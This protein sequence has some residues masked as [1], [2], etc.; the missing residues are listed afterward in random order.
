MDNEWLK[1]KL[2]V[3]AAEAEHLVKDDRLGQ[4]PMPFGFQNEAWKKLL[5]W[6]QEGDE[7]WE[8]CSPK[9]TWECLAGREGV[10][11]L[12]KGKFIGYL[13]TREN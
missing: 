13:I 3:E 2:T 4:E 1:R 6:M 11:L 12:R 7:L 10:A 5:S 9:E 8:F